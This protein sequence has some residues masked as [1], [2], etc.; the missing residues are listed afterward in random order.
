MY[1]NVLYQYIYIYQVLSNE[2]VMNI[3]YELNILKWFNYCT[4]MWYSTERLFNIP[5]MLIYSLLTINN[6]KKSY[7]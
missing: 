5:V 7:D 1:V 3:L 2:P 4:C 6:T